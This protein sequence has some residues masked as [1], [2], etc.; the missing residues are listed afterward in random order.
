MK[1]FLDSANL[2]EI[3]E[4]EAMGIL[5]GVTTNPSL[6]AKEPIDT[7]ESHVA[8]ICRIV[9]GPVSAEVTATEYE[10]IMREARH[11]AGIAENVVVK[12]PMIRDGVK[13]IKTCME[14]GI[15]TNCTLV[16]SANQALIAAKAGAT[17]VSPFI[18]RLDDAGHDGMDVIREIV[19][20]FDNFGF[21]TEVLVASIRHPL[22]VVQAAIAGGDVATVPF[23]VFDQL[24]QHPLTDKGLERFL[25]DWK[26]VE[27][28][29]Q[30]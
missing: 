5:D 20:I 18:G 15:R 28:R 13:A 27:S 10:L 3:R 2:A 4:A 14:E 17:Y 30:V 22:H 1:F 8:E 19:T 29:V 26:K 25:S 11:L 12:I 21:D 23:K 24:I 6:V 16:F 7:F 9:D